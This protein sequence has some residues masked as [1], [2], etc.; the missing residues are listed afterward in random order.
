[1]TTSNLGRL[2]SIAV[3]SHQPRRTKSLIYKPPCSK[4]T[5]QFHEMLPRK[6][7][8]PASGVAQIKKVRVEVLGR[9][10][11]SKSTFLIYSASLR[12]RYWWLIFSH[13][14]LAHFCFLSNLYWVKLLLYPFIKDLSLAS[15]KR[16][17]FNLLTIWMIR[18][19]FFGSDP[20]PNPGSQTHKWVCDSC[21][22][23]ITN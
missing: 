13:Y 19:L 23:P 6:F 11:C 4:N 5:L 12:L 16:Q 18:L 21:L 7:F 15:W 3:A 1:M 10:I 9:G 17:Y 14:K 20:H 2:C 22:K 8:H